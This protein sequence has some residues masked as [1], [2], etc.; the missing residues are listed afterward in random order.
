MPVKIEAFDGNLIE[1]QLSVS[2]QA[3]V[4]LKPSVPNTIPKGYDAIFSI[5]GVLYEGHD[6]GG[7]PRCKPG[8]VV[9]GDGVAVR[10]DRKNPCNAIRMNIF[11][12]TP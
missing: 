9:L 2:P 4:R 1:M 7:R 12:W 8:A 3:K 5:D 11:H 6:F 10:L